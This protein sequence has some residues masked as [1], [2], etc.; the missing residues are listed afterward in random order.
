[1][2]KINAGI[3]SSPGSLIQNPIPKAAPAAMVFP[4][5]SNHTHNRTENATAESV[6]P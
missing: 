1:M 6:F 2:K 5:E 3:A 4:R